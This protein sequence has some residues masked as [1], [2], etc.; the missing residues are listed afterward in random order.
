MKK[1][2]IIIGLATLLVI[3]LLTCTEL[4]TNLWFSI[5]GRGFILPE[6]SSIFTFKVTKM[7]EGS[8]EWWLYAED[9]NYFYTMEKTEADKLYTKI[10]KEKAKMILTFDKYDYRSWQVQPFH[11]K[12]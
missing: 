7:N 5:T 12:E 10:S 6:E 3:T 11:S 9:K 4:P 8:G 2:I 1:G